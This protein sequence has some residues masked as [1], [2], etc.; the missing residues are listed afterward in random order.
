VAYMRDM[1]RPT[2]AKPTLPRTDLVRYPETIGNTS[3]PYDRPLA[4]RMDNVRFFER[5]LNRAELEAIRK[6]DVA[7]VSVNLN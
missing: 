3:R 2:P 4:G 6:A 5:V 1:T 7:N